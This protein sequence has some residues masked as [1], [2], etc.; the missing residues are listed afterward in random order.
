MSEFGMQALPVK[1][2]I[3]QYASTNDLDT[4]SLV[5]RV[6]QKHPTG[7]S[8]INRYLNMEHIA[9]T[10][11]DSYIEATQSLQ[12]KA[13]AWTINAQLHSKGRCMG[14]LIWQFNDCWPVCSWSLIDYYGRKKKAYD[15][16]KSIYKQQP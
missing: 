11:F 6:H 14:S 3:M 12:S 8:T 7:Y 4:N 15:T 9:Y 16:I 13:L 5:M 10:D 1:E 2:S